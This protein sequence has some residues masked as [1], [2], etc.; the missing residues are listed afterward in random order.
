MLQDDQLPLG[1]QW[2]D[3]EENIQAGSN[4]PPSS[5]VERTSDRTSLLGIRTI[6][7]LFPCSPNFVLFCRIWWPTSQH[8]GLD[9]QSHCSLYANNVPYVWNGMRWPTKNS[10]VTPEGG[11]FPQGLPTFTQQ[12]LYDFPLMTA[13]LLKGLKLQPKL[14]SF[15]ACPKCHRLH[16]ANQSGVCPSFCTYQWFPNSQSCSTPLLDILTKQLLRPHL[17]HWFQDWLQGLP[18]TPGIQRPSL[19]RSRAPCHALALLVTPPHNLTF[20]LMS[21]LASSLSRHS[22]VVYHV[23]SRLFCG[24]TDSIR[25]TLGGMWL[26]YVLMVAKDKLAP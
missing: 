17:Y 21:L 22:L 14:T 26:R 16:P 12:P 11:M 2:V 25:E 23:L 9:G 24:C 20:L 3:C 13:K 15:T 10:K 1:G 6:L 18:S 7:M 8:Y 5:G 4:D 19:P